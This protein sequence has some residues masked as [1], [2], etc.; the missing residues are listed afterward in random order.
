MN[1][2]TWL[3]KIA[4]HRYQQHC[5]CKPDDKQFVN[6]LLSDGL[7]LK[8]GSVDE[9]I[10]TPLTVDD[11]QLEFGMALAEA[12]SSMLEDQLFCREFCLHF[13]SKSQSVLAQRNL[14]R[15]I[16]KE[17]VILSC[18][19]E[20]GLDDFLYTVADNYSVE[21]TKQA[22]QERKR[23]DE[24]RFLEWLKENVIG[25]FGQIENYIIGFSIPKKKVLWMFIMHMLRLHIR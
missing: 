3:E 8:E 22:E 15:E 18:I 4:P 10:D 24:K 16:A 21:L 11:L 20:M 14:T 6:E 19:Q 7:V 12:F 17:A 5:I 1:I 9:Y 2:T 25:R 13:M 23:L